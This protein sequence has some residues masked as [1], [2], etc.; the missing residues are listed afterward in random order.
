MQWNNLIS[1]ALVPRLSAGLGIAA[2]AFAGGN[3][4]NPPVYGEHLMLINKR[5][6]YEGR[7]NRSRSEA[8]RNEIREQHQIMIQKRAREPGVNLFAISSQVTGILEA[9]IPD[10]KSVLCAASIA[11]NTD[12]D[13]DG[14]GF[15]HFWITGSASSVAAPV[16][17]IVRASSRA[18]PGINTGGN[19][20]SIGDNYEATL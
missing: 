1:L 4:L 2:E 3:E 13:T 19:E 6:R 10:Y 14:N 17:S 8:Q 15:P 16:K 20:T 18:L 5:K 9:A 11:S 12:L 7:L